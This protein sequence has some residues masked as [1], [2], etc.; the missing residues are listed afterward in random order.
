MKIDNKG[1]QWNR[2]GGEIEDNEE[3][4]YEYIRK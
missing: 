1:L 4:E 3:I 2:C